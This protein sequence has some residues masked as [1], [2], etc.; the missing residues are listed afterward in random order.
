[1][2]KERKNQDSIDLVRIE[3]RLGNSY[4]KFMPGATDDTELAQLEQLVRE[5]ALSGST[6]EDLGEFLQVLEDERTR[7]YQEREEEYVSGRNTLFQRMKH[8]LGSYLGTFNP[9]AIA[10]MECV[11]GV[12]FW[13]AAADGDNIV[14]D[15][16]FFKGITAGIVGAISTIVGGI[17]GA[18][19][20]SYE[21]GFGTFLGLNAIGNTAAD[22]ATYAG[23]SNDS[24]ENF[25]GRLQEEFASTEGKRLNRRYELFKERAIAT[26]NRTRENGD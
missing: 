7:I 21:I 15:R 11:P 1:M 22:L 2:R 8:D 25:K 19:T 10:A 14:M 13:N 9:I 23:M 24:N 18:V 4:R 3:S 20:G 5:Q 12:K 6:S 26:Y 17:S 16:G